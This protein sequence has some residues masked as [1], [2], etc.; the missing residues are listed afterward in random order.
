MEQKPTSEN[1][2]NSYVS[3]KLYEPYKSLNVKE[4][5]HLEVNRV[6]LLHLMLTRKSFPVNS[7][8]PPRFF[9][10]LSKIGMWVHL[11]VRVLV[12][13][14]FIKQHCQR[15]FIKFPTNSSL[16][17]KYYRKVYEFGISP[18]IQHNRTFPSSSF[19][20]ELQSRVK[21][22]STNCLLDIPVD[23][24]SRQLQ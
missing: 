22:N 19:N 21:I 1:V 13:K 23:N 9:S 20:T 2:Y 12:N 18:S 16:E 14:Y 4:T 7:W 24:N 17:R 5:R 10:I 8:N 15:L 11:S 3:A 6:D